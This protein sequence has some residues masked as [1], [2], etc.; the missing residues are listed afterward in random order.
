MPVNLIQLSFR[1]GIHQN[2]GQVLA[3]NKLC[4]KFS[5]IVPLVWYLIGVL[6]AQ[7]SHLPAFLK[8]S[9]VVG[10][11]LDSSLKVLMHK[12]EYLL[13]L[14]HSLLCERYFKAD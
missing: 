13:V 1:V 5:Y 11:P 14:L 3:E 9:K 2:S 6:E 7:S 12:L 10:S 4:C 8:H